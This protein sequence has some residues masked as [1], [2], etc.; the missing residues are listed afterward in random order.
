MADKKTSNLD[1]VTTLADG[2][3]IIG[4][5]TT[6]TTF[7]ITWANVKTLLA[8]LYAP[9]A[10]GVTNGDT[11]DHVGGDGAA[12]VEA[13]ITL[14][15]N[16]TN[17]VSITKHGFAPKAP[18]DAAK[19][20]DG[21]GAWTTPTSASFPI[22]SLM[23]Y[24]GAAAPSDWLLCNG[25][26]V[27]RTTYADLFGVISTT[28]GAGDGS[29][30]FNVPDMRGRIPIGV[31]TGI[32]GGASGT[33]LPAGGSALTAVARAGWKGSENHALV[34]AE[35]AAHTHRVA[36]GPYVSAGPYIVPE[37]NNNS[38]SFVTDSTGSGNAHNNIQPVMGLNFIIKT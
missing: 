14:A 6:P 10:K 11:H 28:Y 22:A 18:N 36:G 33:G 16:T 24:G 20:L 27:S 38:G 5:D 34:T 1:V 2:D 12:I 8:A 26:A 37:T 25:A 9:I 23:L 32:G 35:L 29:T 7:R 4:H 31:G 15:D 17:N 13:A 21:T 3:H 19:F 30:T